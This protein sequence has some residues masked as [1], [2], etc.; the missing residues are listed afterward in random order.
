[1]GPRLF[2]LPQPPQILAALQHE[3]QVAWDELP[4][5]T[6]CIKLKYSKNNL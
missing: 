5:L 3:V 6:V 2:R 1:M 4:V